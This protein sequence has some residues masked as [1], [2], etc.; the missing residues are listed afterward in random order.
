MNK[1]VEEEVSEEEKKD[2][3]RPLIILV[4]II[5]V[6]WLFSLIG[7]SY[8]INSPTERG[9]F[10]DSFG[11]INALFSGFA[12]AGIIYTIL[13]QRKELSLQRIEL[14]ETRKE[15]RR[16]ADAQEKSEKA[17]IKQIENMKIA[18]KVSALNTLLSHY[19]EE[20][21]RGMP[22]REKQPLLNKRNEYLKEI[23]GTL[24]TI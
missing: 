5:I 10:G 3:F 14:R 24:K 18:A 6:L 12:F 11:A 15:L 22:S 2:N 16:S 13:L 4:S 17:L 19:N 7:L 23:E 21:K 8:F 20:V 9:T 1:K